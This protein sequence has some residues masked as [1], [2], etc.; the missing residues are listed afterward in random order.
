[1]TVFAD[2]GIKTPGGQPALPTTLILGHQGTGK[3][4]LLC[5]MVRHVLLTRRASRVVW[6]NPLGLHV[7]LNPR[8]A[9]GVEYPI[10]ESRTVPSGEIPETTAA[11]ITYI[12]GAV[13]KSSQIEAWLT[14]RSNPGPTVYVCDETTALQASVGSNALRRAM[15]AHAPTM[16]HRNAA[17]W[18]AGQREVGFP[19]AMRDM[20]HCRVNMSL[21][22]S[23][24]LSDDETWAAQW[25][26]E[27]RPRALSLPFFASE[28]HRVQTGVNSVVVRRNWFTGDTVVNVPT[29]DPLSL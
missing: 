21:A 27:G 5:A 2:A 23:D 11:R 28:P 15:S 20:A 24:N 7:P 18:L 14:M 3:T 19:K 13:T 4:S 26:G 25:D 1:M 6:L 8:S 29:L 12:Q 22:V 9:E 10:W 16:R 17:I